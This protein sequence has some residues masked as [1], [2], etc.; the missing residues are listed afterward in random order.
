M[1]MPVKLTC[2]MNLV[3]HLLSLMF[4]LSLYVSDEFDGELRANLKEPWED[5]SVREK[6]TPIP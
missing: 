1:I 4:D 5:D 2:L 3:E 6:I